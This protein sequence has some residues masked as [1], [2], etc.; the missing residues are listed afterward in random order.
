MKV[1]NEEKSLQLDLPSSNQVLEDW[2][3]TPEIFEELLPFY[4]AFDTNLNVCAAGPA[5]ER[6]HP[7]IVGKNFAEFFLPQCSPELLTFDV[8]VRAKAKSKSYAVRCACGDDH[9]DMICE[10]RA[11]VSEGDSPVVVYNCTPSEFSFGCLICS[12]LKIS[13]F[14][15]SSTIQEK[16]FLSLHLYTAEIVKENLKATQRQLVASR[17]NIEAKKKRS[18]DVLYSVLPSFA[19]DRYLVGEDFPP[20]KIDSLTVVFSNIV[21]FADIC[22]KCEPASTIAML[23]DLFSKYDDL[24]DIHDLLKVF[25][26]L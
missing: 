10:G 1:G 25:K 5:L 22:K 8:F 9:C 3:I 14:H 12:G 7:S 17:E 18:L 15:Y 4:V 13:D 26:L 23:S 6:L 19:V 2:L 20:T 11:I 16:I 24:T 21:G